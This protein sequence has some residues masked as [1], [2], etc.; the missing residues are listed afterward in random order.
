MLTH[1]AGSAFGGIISVA[2]CRVRGEDCACW[3]TSLGQILVTKREG[4]ALKPVKTLHANPSDY[5]DILQLA[6]WMGLVVSGNNNGTLR[7]WDID[8]GRVMYCVQAH[9]KSISAL[10]VCSSCCAGGPGDRLVSGS[11]GPGNGKVLL[12]AAGTGAHSI[13]LLRTRVFQ[14]AVRC[15]VSMGGSGLAV[16]CADGVVVVWDTL[17]RTDSDENSTDRRLDVCKS[18]TLP[19]LYPFMDEG[20]KALASDGRL[21]VGTDGRKLEVWAVDSDEG[22]GAGVLVKAVEAYAADSFHRV[23]SLAM[24]A[25]KLITGS[26]IRQGELACEVCVRDVTTLRVEHVLGGDSSWRGGICTAEVRVLLAERGRVWGG[27]CQGAVMWGYDDSKAKTSSESAPT[28]NASRF[29]KGC[30]TQ[31]CWWL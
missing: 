9:D 6:T 2:I 17:A 3:G 11:G 30:L 10:A 16:G 12:W 5:S 1:T 15:M 22:R 25:G 31:L 29:G 7:L 19:F 18:S 27:V 8:T 26:R 28:K 21:L 14:H 13:V 24:H 23:Q 20:L 4:A